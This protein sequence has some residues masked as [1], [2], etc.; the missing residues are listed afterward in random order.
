MICS[1]IL[2]FHNLSKLKSKNYKKRANPRNIFYVNV[3]NSIKDN[4]FD[5]FDIISQSSLNYSL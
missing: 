3:I 5:H 2:G 4:E 1:I